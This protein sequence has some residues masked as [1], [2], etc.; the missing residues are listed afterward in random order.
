M[1]GSSANNHLHWNFSGLSCNVCPP[2]TSHMVSSSSS[3]A[4]GSLPLGFKKRSSRRSLQESSATGGMEAS[5]RCGAEDMATVRESRNRLLC[6]RGNHSLSLVV[7]EN[8][9]IKSIWCRTWDFFHTGTNPSLIDCEPA[10]VHTIASARTVSIHQLYAACFLQQ[11]L[12]S[13]KAASTLKVYVA[14]ISAYHVPVNGSSLGSHA[15][16]CSFLKGTR[17]LRPA[18]KPNFQEWHLPLVLDF[19]CSPPFEPL[20]AADLRWASLKSVFFCWPSL[21]Q[22]RLASYMPCPLM[23]YACIDC[24]KILG[25]CFDQT[26]LFPPKFYFLSL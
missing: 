5:P 9:D 26:H 11:L 14:A 12:E 19:L 24:Q 7:C 20:H 18:H 4:E 22:S 13:D 3:I 2:I 21:R 8:I 25:F 23:S 15:L 6:D 1:P 10:V 17:R 16:I